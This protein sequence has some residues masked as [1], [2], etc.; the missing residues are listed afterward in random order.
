MLEHPQA[1]SHG[2]CEG[3]ALERNP[4]PK[5]FQGTVMPVLSPRQ[6]QPV[7]ELRYTAGGGSAAHQPPTA[8]SFSSSSVLVSPP[9]AQ[10]EAGEEPCSPLALS[11][12]EAKTHRHTFRLM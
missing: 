8:D 5:D 3:Q 2:F 6:T 1:S 9:G 12:R 7:P 11:L 4:S 10:E